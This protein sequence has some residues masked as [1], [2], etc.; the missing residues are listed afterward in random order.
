MTLHIP[1]TRALKVFDAASRHLNFSRAA[2]ELG[3]TPAAVSHQIKETEDQLGMAL[4]VRSSRSIRLTEAGAVFHEAA[5]EALEG[6][7]KA[8]AR[9]KKLSRGLTHLKLTMDGTFASKWMVPRLDRFRARWPDMDLRFDISYDLRDFDHDDVDVAIRFGMGKYPG[10]T[11]HRLFD[12]VIFPVCSPRLLKSGP[13]LKVPRDLLR[14]TLVHIEWSRQGVTWPNWRMWM[15]AAGVEDFDDSRCVLFASS[16]YV[17]QAAIEGSV[18]ALC[19]F[20]MVANDLSEGRLV[21]PFDLGIKVRP[22]F[23]YHLAYPTAAADDPRIAAFRDWILEEARQA[24]LE[25]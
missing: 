21:R 14:H 5:V 9:A 10:V 3:L 15:A 24:S 1:G 18:V 7:A 11:T 2:E 23:A 8:V 17:I 16:S 25:S 19:D 20:S 13:P 4:F 6:L 22:E 12:N